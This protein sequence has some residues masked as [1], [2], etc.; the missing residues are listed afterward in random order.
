MRLAKPARAC[1]VALLLALITTW[2]LS[3]TPQALAW[4]EPGTLPNVP[5]DIYKQRVAAEGNRFHEVY[6]RRESSELYYQRGTGSANGSVTWENPRVLATGIGNGWNIAAANGVVHIVYASSDRRMLYIRNERNG[7]LGNWSA[8]EQVATGFRQANEADIVLDSA[9][10]PYVAFGQDVDDSLLTVAY[11]KGAS[12]WTSY[13]LGEEAY[14][15]RNAQLV[16]SGEGAGAT[17]HVFSEL[18]P[19]SSS[20]IRIAYATGPRDGPFDIR[21]FSEPFSGGSRLAQQPTI[22]ID[23]TT[24]TLFVSF[25]S[26]KDLEFDLFF[27]YSANNGATWQPAILDPFGSDIAVIEKSP[28][29][30]LPGGAYI[31][32]DTRQIQNGSFAASGFFAS[33]FSTSTGSFSDPIAARPYAGT[34]FKNVEPDLAIG[35]VSKIATWVFGFT[36]GVGYSSDPGGIT[37][38]VVGP[39]GEAVVTNSATNNNPN[40][41]VNINKI[42]GNPTQMQVAFDSVPTDATPKEA[43]QPTFTRRAPDAASCARTINLVLLDATGKKSSTL[44]SNFTLDISVQASAVARN[45]YKREN[46]VIYTADVGQTPSDGDSNYTRKQAFYVEIGGSN[47]CSGLKQVRIGSSAQTLGA[48]FVIS[49][50]FFANVLPIPGDVQIG[51]NRVFIESTDN[52]GNTQ[53]ISP[54]IYYDPTPPVFQTKG[55]VSAVAPTSGPNVLVSLQFRGNAL[56]DNM[57]ANRGFWGVWVANSRTPITNP[58]TDTVLGWAAVAAPGNTADFTLSNWNLLNNIPVASQTPGD[59]YVYVRF[60]DGAGNPTNDFISTKVTLSA[61]TKPTVT[62]PLISK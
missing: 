3:V 43:F 28:M 4:T 36:A 37:P 49:G 32:F 39:G 53:L 47:E 20:Q 18:K 10:T 51:P 46:A 5:N 21:N 41:T 27:T 19:E 38:P 55:S 26:G 6:V 23:R 62:L 15:Y 7:D 45:P 29:V 40:I 22:A 50:N 24:N 42:V 61:I 14:F 9:G 56:S 54:T 35:D 48:P 60:L 34:E 8:P 13:R 17:V 59:Y 30:G 16:V 57:Y 25:F 11:R 33:T 12:S 1:L 44:T 2:G 31:L 58:I 52:A